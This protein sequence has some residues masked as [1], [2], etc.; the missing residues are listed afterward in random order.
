MK[1]TCKRDDLRR[2]LNSLHTIARHTERDTPYILI[3]TSVRSQA[4]RMRASSK[5]MRG[6]AIL[7]EGVIV[8]GRGSQCVHGTIFLDAVSRLSVAE[9]EDMMV[10]I[11]GGLFRIVSAD[12]KV[13]FKTGILSADKLVRYDDR[14]SDSGIEVDCEEFKALI[15]RVKFAALYEYPIKFSMRNNKL[16]LIG[17]GGHRMCIDSIGS[18]SDIEASVLMSKKSL[19]LIYKVANSKTGKVRFEWNSDSASIKGDE[20]VFT[21]PIVN[22]PMPNYSQIIETLGKNDVVVDIDIKTLKKHLEAFLY[23]SGKENAP[24]KLRIHE[25]NILAELK[26][27]AIG[28][29]KCEFGCG[30]SGDE[31]NIAFNPHYIHELTRHISS[32][33]LRI[34][35]KSNKIPALFEIPN[36]DLQ[37]VLSP[38]YVI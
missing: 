2:I 16:F 30:Y 22:W 27:P 5:A 21:M 26:N 24:I 34:K 33:T 23:F 8:D 37:Y 1:F 19:E 9:T 12:K 38:Y 10:E 7:R 3:E 25:N 18:D 15:N 36:S 17:V 4:I 6:R 29:V 31:F 20:S 14:P 35:M 11:V 13:E 32:G 28:E